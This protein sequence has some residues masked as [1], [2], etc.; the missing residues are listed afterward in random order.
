MSIPERLGKYRIVEVLGSGAMGVVYRALDPD[1][2]REVAV[3]T[4]LRGADGAPASGV[5]LAERFRN[6]AQAGG[7]LQHP[8][9]VA[10]FDYGR[11]EGTAFIAMEYVAGHTLSRYLRQA[12]LG[13]LTIADDDVLSIVG[14]LLEALH[15][16][17][18]QGVWHRDIKPS[19]LIMTRQGKIK[20]TDFGIA[21]IQSAELT[22]VASLVGTPMYMAP[23]QFRGKAIDRRVDLYASGVVLYQLLTGQLPFTGEPESLMYKVVHEPLTLPSQLPGLQRLRPY[24]A[25]LAK[26][27]AKEP[28]DRYADALEFRDALVAVVG[29]MHN[30]AVSDATVTALLPA[31]PRA[32]GPGGGTTS[33]PPPTHFSDTDLSQAEASLARHL[34]PLARVLVRR[35]A[36]ETAD[37]PGLYTW[38]AAQVTDAGARSALLVL[39]DQTLGSQATGTG[40]AGA[41]S[42]QGSSLAGG[43]ALAS[44]FAPTQ[45]LGPPP[46]ATSPPVSATLRDA[47]QRLLA[48][49][50]GPIAAVVVKRAAAAEP[51]RAGF[52]ERLVQA[53]DDPTA[54][55]RLA[56][57]LA[58]LPD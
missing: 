51:H 36:R 7:R 9:I 58:R 24:D 43:V 10:V 25:V 12:A 33:G 26:A 5:S 52:L 29:R 1:I 48:Q 22:Q 28:A 39:R 17:H 47:A 38:L 31:M 15:H 21:R 14:Q 45:R 3:K 32:P 34:G 40:R 30:A 56:E 16:A 11:D 42:T 37:L 6:E 50:L 41:P 35:G 54:R 13:E 4:L 55:S 44:A 19:N 2:Q 27:L 57:A 49:Q 20:V 18:E 8:G 53:V 23:E 46:A